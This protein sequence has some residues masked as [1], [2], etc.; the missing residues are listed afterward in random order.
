[1]ECGE[2]TRE[3][4]ARECYEETG[5]VVEDVGKFNLISIYNLP[6]QVQLLY[7]LQVD[8][9]ISHSENTLESLEVKLFSY[10]DIPWDDLA[11]PTVEWA[12]KFASSDKNGIIQQRTKAYDAQAQ[13]W[14]VVDS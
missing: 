5:F 4:A 2:T 9:P 13:S 8:G 14:T 11:F 7:D 10:D 12:L 3:C 1:M 6:N